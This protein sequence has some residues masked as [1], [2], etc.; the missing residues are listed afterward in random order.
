[1]NNENFT[2]LCSETLIHLCVL[3]A[4]KDTERIRKVLRK[5][6]EDVKAAALGNGTDVMECS[7]LYIMCL[8]MMEKENDTEGIHQVLQKIQDD[9]EKSIGC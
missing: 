8:C 5:T 2:A 3:E 1:M 9:L 4:D 7:A 6:A